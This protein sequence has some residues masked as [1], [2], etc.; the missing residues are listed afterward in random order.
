MIELT[1]YQLLA[2][3]GT[4]SIISGI[5]LIV[6][7]RSIAKR[8]KKREKIE[9]ARV[10]LEGMLVNG[11]GTS[12]SLGVATANS[13]K[14]IDKTANGDLDKAIDKAV[15]AKDAMRN[16]LQLEGIKAVF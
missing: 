4:P 3:V 11:V 7:Q 10:K 13:V 16:Y 6:I 12:I 14:K 9:D 15:E 8:D 1:I 2:L 5:F